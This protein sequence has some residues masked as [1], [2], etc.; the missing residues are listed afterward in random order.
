MTIIVYILLL[1]W[2][3]I[4]SWY[5]GGG[6]PGPNRHNVVDAIRMTVVAQ[7]LLILPLKK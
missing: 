6:E 3:L 4:T 1:F 5:E 7:L 2:A